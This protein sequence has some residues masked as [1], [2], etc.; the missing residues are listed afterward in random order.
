[1]DTPQALTRLWDDTY[2]IEYCLRDTASRLTTSVAPTNSSTSAPRFSSPSKDH[3]LLAGDEHGAIEVDR[4]ILSAA[5]TAMRLTA[6]S[7]FERVVALLDILYAINNS[8]VVE[9]DG[10]PSF[11]SSLSS[12]SSSVR[13]RH[14][15]GNKE[16][17]CGKIAQ[18]LLRQLQ[19]TLTLCSG[20]LPAW[21]ATLT[22]NNKWMFPFELRQ[23]YFRSTSFGISRALVAL[24]EYQQQ[25]SGGNSSSSSGSGEPQLRIG[26]PPRQ[27]F[28][29]SRDRVLECAQQVMEKVVESAS[30]TTGSGGG[31]PKAILEI[32]Y[33]NEVG[34]GLG[35]TLE[36]YTLVCQHIQRADNN[37]WVDN[38][39]SPS[40]SPSSARLVECPGG[41]WPKPLS[42]ASINTPGSQKTLQFFTFLG[43]F[44]AK[45]V[46]DN[47]L[48]DIPFSIAFLKW[49]L[50]VP[51]CIDDLRG[52]YPEIV[53]T[54]K[55]LLDIVHEKNDVMSNNSNDNSSSNR[56]NQSLINDIKFRGSGRL[57][58]AMLT[59]ILPGRE[60]W[61]LVPDGANVFVNNSNV[62]QYVELLVGALLHDSVKH[63]L[64]S[65]RAG[66][67]SLASM[68]S[69]AVY[70]S[71]ELDSLL[72]GS[73]QD[74]VAWDRAT[75]LEH[76]KCDHGYTAS[77]RA[78]HWVVDI[79]ADFTPEER[80]KFLRFA[81]GSS[82]LPPRGLRDMNPKLT[83]VRKEPTQ[84]N[85]SPDSYLPS[86]NT[87]FFYLKLPDYSSKEIMK[88]RLL[89]A[90][91]HG[92][93]SFSFN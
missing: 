47:R 46:M 78:V 43:R 51:L 88:Q 23:L 91:T 74:S 70:F 84:P 81:T 49:M 29:I 79:I 65:F 61:E 33:F 15:V 26:R 24:Q 21:C 1:V 6:T 10:L 35:P 27:K 50:G 60:E 19:D 80:R 55:E 56:D 59:F 32:E 36:F 85:A 90:I 14:L 89:F 3:S 5:S 57:E 71:D 11:S 48:L 34:V 17:E 67:E 76:T 4:V 93:D 13:Q 8:N 28:R 82:R 66:F 52:V 38:P 37:A 92:Q 20:A 54:V 40:S 30:S 12:P 87:C 75:L 69:L 31:G 64:E 72:C 62:E 83:F 18:K 58:D 16:F 86:V 25:D 73:S 39:S 22:H 63:Q 2:T 42:S 53:R 44:V 68:E 41:L 7:E 77:S 9:H 45:A